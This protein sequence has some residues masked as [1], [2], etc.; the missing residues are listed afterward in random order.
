MSTWDGPA[1]FC[2]DGSDGSRAAL[3]AA[4]LRLRPG[5]A[6]VLTVWQSVALRVASHAFATAMPLDNEQELDAEE[7]AAARAAAEE[8]ARVAREHGW[9]AE[10]RLAMTRATPWRTIIDIADEV[11]ASIIVCGTRGLGR[12][13]GL[14]LGSV[15]NALVH[16]AARPVLIAPEPQA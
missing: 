15:S 16:H 13:R 11:D 3:R 7:E 8:G 10:S 4:G 14:V 9:G 5:P 2:F 12:V 1:L 6:I